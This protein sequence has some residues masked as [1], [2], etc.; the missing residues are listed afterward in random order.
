MGLMLQPFWSPPAKN[1]F[2]KGAII[3]FGDVH[4][5]AHIY[6]A[7]YEGICFELRRLQEITQKK[8][9]IPIREIR[10]G[11]GGSRS[12]VAVQIA[13]DM[14]NLPTARMSTSEISSLGA[15]IDAA[16]GIGMYATFEE[17]VAGM[18]RKQKTFEPNAHNHRIYTEL[19]EGVYK[20]A[21]NT[22][23]PLYRRSAQ[24]TGYPAGD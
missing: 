23:E 18:V 10:V 19:F 17:A 21:F 14:F 22:L 6:R 15:A 2:S 20:E 13:A 24:I 5:R 12:D 7:I 3:G 11:G 16:V 9:G 4:T 1:K 8:T